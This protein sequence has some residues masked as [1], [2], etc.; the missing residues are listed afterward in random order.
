MTDPEKDFQNCSSRICRG[1]KPANIP[2][3]DKIINFD[4]IQF[5]LRAILVNCGPQNLFSKKLWPAENF[6]FGMWPSDE[7]QY[8][9]PALGYA[10]N[11]IESVS[12]LT[13]DQTLK[14]Y[15]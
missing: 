5:I 11:R 7:F 10:Q 2:K 13:C 4:Q 9:T 3:H 15:L 1:L 8:E 14:F 12:S 6:F